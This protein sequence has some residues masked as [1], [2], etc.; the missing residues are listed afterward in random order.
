[1]LI[2]ADDDD[3][4][5]VF[6]DGDDGDCVNEECASSPFPPARIT[7][8]DGTH[9]PTNTAVRHTHTHTHIHTHTKG[10]A[11]EVEGTDRTE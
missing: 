9:T 8:G 7:C 4:K 11:G 2:I 1:M 6:A 10:G 3:K 5:F